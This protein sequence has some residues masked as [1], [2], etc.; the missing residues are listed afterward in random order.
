V[1][2]LAERERH[3]PGRAALVVIDVQND[4]CAADGSL[5]RH[6]GFDLE[7]VDAMVPRLQRLIDAARAVG[8][9]VVFVRTVHDESNDSPA[10]LG[11]LGDGDGSERAGVTCRTGTWGAEFFGV[12]PQPGDHVITKHRFSA[13]VGTNL[14][15]TL[16]S[17]GIRSLL[18]TGVATEVCVESSLRDG[19]FHEFYVT[20]VE[21]CAGTYAKAAH[22][23]SVSVVRKHFGLVTTSQELI[24]SWALAEQTGGIGDGGQ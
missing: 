11:R 18:F 10:W 3:I 9:P 14:A 1:S 12:A 2:R 16:T 23:A 24:D 8:M 17:L 20:L 13:F 19:L 22:D 6:Y 4:F 7:F 5:P 21:D 15:I